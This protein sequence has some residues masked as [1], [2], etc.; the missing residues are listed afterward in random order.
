MSVKDILRSKPGLKR[1]T[2]LVYS[3]FGHNTS[4]L[5]GKDNIVEL[6][7]TFRKGCK[8]RVYGSNNHIRF[9]ESAFAIRNVKVSVYG[10]NNTIEVGRDFASDGLT[11]S[12]ED[13]NNS[14]VLGANCH[15]GGAS[16]LAAIEGTSIE[17]GDNCMMS[18]NITVRTGDSHSV[19]DAATGERIN[20]SRSVKIGPHVWIGNTVLIFKG[21]EIGTNS[22]VAGGSVVTGKLFPNNCIIGGNPAKVI[23][24]GVNWCSERK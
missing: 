7:G 22:I 16:E 11:F 17:I 12:I 20:Q 6:S 18:A 4:V 13:D 9:A 15:G 2:A 8:I 1:F 3:A 24:E 21:T 5:K 14:I 10:N 23:K 19:L